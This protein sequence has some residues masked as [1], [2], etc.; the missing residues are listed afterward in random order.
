MN[1]IYLYCFVKGIICNHISSLI[2]FFSVI[3]NL[4][5]TMSTIVDAIFVSDIRSM[6]TPNLISK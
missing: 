3:D 4:V 1:Q 6:S 2:N 5:E